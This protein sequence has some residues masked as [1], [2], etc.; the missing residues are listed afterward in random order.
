MPS[1]ARHIFLCAITCALFICASQSRSIAQSP[2]SH[3]PQRIAAAR[4]LITATGTDTNFDL[5]MR[6]ILAEFA[7][8][9]K[10]QNPAKSA[11]IDKTFELIA[12]KAQ[13]SKA[14]MIEQ[15]AGLY[16]DQ[17]TVDELNRISAFYNS[18]EG[19]KLVAAQP[20]LL[21]K[22]MAAGKAWGEQIIK[23]IQAELLELQKQQTKQ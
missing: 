15:I 11:E 20:D 3:D 17:F 9:A 18:P 13:T 6:P 16:A 2:S 8:L 1:N 10:K 12:T 19:K 7:S 4:V 22:S 23:D 5:M 14:V 21:Q